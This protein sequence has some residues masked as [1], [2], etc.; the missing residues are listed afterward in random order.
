METET[1][2]T[3]VILCTEERGTWKPKFC[4]IPRVFLCSSVREN[5]MENSQIQDRRKPTPGNKNFAHSHLLLK[6]KETNF[7]QNCVT[8]T[9]IFPENDGEFQWAVMKIYYPVTEVALAEPTWGYRISEH[10]GSW[11]SHSGAHEDYDLVTC[12]V[13]IVRQKFCRTFG[14]KHRFRLQL[15]P[16]SWAFLALLTRRPWRWRRYVP[17]KRLW[18]STQ[19]HGTAN[20]NIA[21]FVVESTCSSHLFKYCYVTR[22][23]GCLL[24]VPIWR[25]ELKVRGLSP[26]ANCTDRATAACRRI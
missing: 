17:L 13:H 4:I 15:P 10:W 1:V 23:D 3:K 22:F 11:C 25:K 19:L 21:L 20:H 9:H 18:N 5:M 24:K 12:S 8:V 14:G 2:R 26:R 16:A 6:K 7:S